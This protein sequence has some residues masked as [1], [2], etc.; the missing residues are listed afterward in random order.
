MSFLTLALDCIQLGTK[1]LS[2]Q[3][4]FGCV[5][6]FYCHFIIFDMIRVIA[7]AP[8]LIEKRYLAYLVFVFIKS[9]KLSPP[10]LS[11]KLRS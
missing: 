11:N 10:G 4:F 3:K 1:I 8:L 6:K 7:E 5:Q 2:C 9:V